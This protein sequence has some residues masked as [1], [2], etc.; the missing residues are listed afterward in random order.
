MCGFETDINVPLIVRGPGVAAGKEQFGVTSHT[1]LAP[2]IMEL[3]G[4]PLLASFD[5][6][7]IPLTGNK[8]HR[9]EH[10]GVEYWGLVTVEGIYGAG[11]NFFNHTYKSVRIIGA[12]YNLYYSVWCTNEKELYDMNVGADSWNLLPL[13]C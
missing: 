10:L 13:L 11:Y 5:G 1:D 4:N 12:E 8:K 7:P 9:P 3:A 6:E 2:T